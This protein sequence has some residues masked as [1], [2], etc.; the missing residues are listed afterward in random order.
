MA[1][2]QFA[3]LSGQPVKR[4]VAQ[5]QVT[6]RVIGVGIETGTAL[7]GSFG[8]ARRRTHTVLG[9]TV[10]VAAR[11][12]A[13]TADV[14]E[15]ILLGSGAAKHLPEG[16]LYSLGD[17]LLEGLPALPWLQQCWRP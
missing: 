5:A 4:R 8:L 6:E 9:Q 2:S 15:P 17:F 1:V 12:Q 7:V 14:A 13:L 3:D 11:L 10:T 16:T